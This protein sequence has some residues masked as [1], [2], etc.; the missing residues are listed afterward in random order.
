MNGLNNVDDGPVHTYLVAMDPD[1]SHDELRRRRELRRAFLR[2]LYLD[3]D[4]SV[5]QFVT[6]FDIG[7]ALHLDQ[8][9]TRR[10]FEYLEEKGWVMVDD[11]RAGVVRL[12]A[13]GVDEVESEA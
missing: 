1:H 12:T 7:A 11:H 2:R 4:G 3:V 13:N 9:A 6:A 8:D 5:S 10:I